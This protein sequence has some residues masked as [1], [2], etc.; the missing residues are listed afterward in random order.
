[1]DEFLNL[2]HDKADSVVESMN[3]MAI[4]IVG[5]WIIEKLSHCGE[6]VHLLRSY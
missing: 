3:C 4:T 1:M 2:S 5:H 6:E